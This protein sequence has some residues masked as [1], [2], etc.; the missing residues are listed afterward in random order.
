VDPGG[1]TDALAVAVEAG[2]GAATEGTTGVGI[3]DVPPPPAATDGAGTGATATT[4]DDSS[5]SLSDE[6]SSDCNS[7][8]S[9]VLL[10]MNQKYNVYIYR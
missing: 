2:M 10:M 6:S 4:G 3:T 5:L 1:F 7:I 9:I 8:L